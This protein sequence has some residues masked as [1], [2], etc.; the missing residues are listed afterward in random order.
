MKKYSYLL[1]WLVPVVLIVANIALAFT[2]T[3]PLLAKFTNIILPFGIYLFLMGLWKRTGIAALLSLPFM[4]YSAFQIVLLFLYGERIIAVDM[5]LNVAT[6]NFTEATELLANLVSAIVTVCI[7]YLPPLVWGGILAS[8][9]ICTAA[10]QRHKAVKARIISALAGAGA[11]VACYITVPGYAVSRNLFPINVISNMCEAIMRFHAT[12]NYP[13]TSAGFVF[14]AQSTRPDSLQEIYVMVVGETARACNWQLAGYNR[15]T[16]PRLA[17]RHDIVFFNRVLSESNTTHKSVPMI[18]SPLDASNFGDSIYHTKSIIE[19]FN[20]A[21]YRTAFISNQKRNGSFIDFFG[22]QADETIFINDGNDNGER[23]DIDLIDEMESFI[24]RNSDAR[25]LMIVLH[26]YGSHFKYEGRYPASSA[27]FTPDNALD[28]TASNRP[29][30]INAYDNTIAYTDLFLDS[31]ASCLGATGRPS[32]FVY[33]SDHGED[34]FDDERERF[35]HASPNPTYYQIHVPMLLWMSDSLRTIEPEKFNTA[36]GHA[37]SK[38]SSSKSAFNTL[39]NLAGITTP[40][41]RPAWSVTDTAFVEQPRIYLNDY[42]ES[43]RLDDSGLR[44][45]DFEILNKSKVL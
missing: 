2:E 3:D 15:P 27:V 11:L 20:E 19:T 28:A 26:T 16:T 1:I 7:L 6:T 34:I 29:T 35:L 22:N 40:S 41:Y 8:K 21:G 5:F 23:F 4:I 44:R 9:G 13:Q 17:R 37:S 31:L 42:N 14:D 30:L 18:L 39:I 38:I 45:Q 33:L 32:A 24:S 36:V 12:K 25:K 10:N 43:V